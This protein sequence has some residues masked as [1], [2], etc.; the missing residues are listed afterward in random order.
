MCT[1]CACRIPRSP[2]PR[3]RS[4][5]R[6]AYLPGRQCRVLAAGLGRGPLRRWG[7]AEGEDR[8]SPDRGRQVTYPGITA[9]EG[10]RSGN[11][12][13]QIGRLPD[14]HVRL[15]RPS[16]MARRCQ[17]RVIRVG[18]R[19]ERI[20]R[21]S[22]MLQAPAR[23]ALRQLPGRALDRLGAVLATPE[24]LHSSAG[25]RSRRRSSGRRPVVE[26]RVDAEHRVQ[27]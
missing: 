26:H 21:Q 10:A 2:L 19:I 1:G 7:R 13:R 4:R 11:Q 20:G 17:L 9:D 25:R 12:R 15:G 14:E 8:L 27:G 6:I 3:V 22:T 24:A 23:R 18:D 16:A 5:V